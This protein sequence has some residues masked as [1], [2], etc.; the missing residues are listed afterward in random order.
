MVG[1]LGEAWRTGRCCLEGYAESQVTVVCDDHWDH[2]GVCG[3]TGVCIGGVSEK[4]GGTGEPYSGSA[5][6]SHGGTGV[7]P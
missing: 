6:G 3:S 5:T 7:P 1:V 4:R 2:G